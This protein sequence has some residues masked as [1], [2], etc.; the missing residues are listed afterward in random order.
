MFFFN[1]AECCAA[2]VVRGSIKKQNCPN[3][4]RIARHSP[5]CGSFFCSPLWYLLLGSPRHDCA[6][7]AASRHLF[8]FDAVFSLLS[9]AA[10]AAVRIWRRDNWHWVFVNHILGLRHNKRPSQL[11]DERRHDGNVLEVFLDCAGT[12]P[13]WTAEHCTRMS[14]WA[15]AG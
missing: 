6:S 3:S 5:R 9:L 14:R 2:G 8:G 1:R 7:A 4:P 15:A 12:T 13:R 11:C 10:A